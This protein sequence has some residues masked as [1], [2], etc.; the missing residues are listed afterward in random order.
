MG[1]P[2]HTAL[3]DCFFFTFADDPLSVKPEL[4]HLQVK[5]EVREVSAFSP[6]IEGIAIGRLLSI[7]VLSV[8]GL[9]ASLSCYSV[10]SGSSPVRRRPVTRTSPPPL[11]I[12]DMVK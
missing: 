8:L 7:F 11:V 3:P 4:R 9:A 10:V 1:H 6:N 2:V 12:G 5:E